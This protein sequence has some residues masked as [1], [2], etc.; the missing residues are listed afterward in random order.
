MTNRKGTIKEID[1]KSSALNETIKISIYLPEFYSPLYTYPVLFALDGD[2]YFRLG[3]LVKTTEELVDKS[4]IE[5]CIIVGIPYKSIQDRRDKYHPNG[6]EHEAFKLFL[7]ELTTYI[8]KEYATH[9]LASGHILMGDSLAGTASF[10][11]GLEYP[12]TFGKVIMQSPLVDDIV[13]QMAEKFSNSSHLSIYHVIGTEETEV[14]LTNGKI[15]DF[16]TP[17]RELNKILL[18]KKID[19]FYNEFNGGH[20]WRYWQPDIRK[21]MIFTIQ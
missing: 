18:N 16:L 10:L 6:A 8:D 11:T 2:D 13:L 17:N 21:A 7:L 3:K 9:Q 1:F 4:E 14:K 5:D 12:N 20:L 15:Q 19:Y